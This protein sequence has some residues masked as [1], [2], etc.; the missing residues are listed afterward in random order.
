M[1]HLGT[2]LI[3]TAPLLACN[4]GPRVTEASLTSAHADAISDSVATVLASWRSAINALDVDRAAAFYLADATFRWIE[5]GVV[6]YRSRVEV[7]AAIRE[8]VGSV[9][10]TELLLDGTVI[11]PLAPGV[12][13]VTTGF[14]QKVVDRDGRVGGFAGAISAV[15]VHR[16]EG[17]MFQFGHTSSGAPPRQ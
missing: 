15:L 1:R 13:A 3:M 8:L 17:W 6:R 14:A 5:D 9:R 11:T 16:E 10:G 2:I 7:A 12:A 4:P